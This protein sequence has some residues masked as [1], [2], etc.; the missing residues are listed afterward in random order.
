MDSVVA[1]MVAVALAL[2]LF[3]IFGFVLVIY[4]RWLKEDCIARFYI[5][6]QIFVSLIVLSLGGY[7]ASHVHGFQTSFEFFDSASRFPYYKIMYYGAVGQAAFGVLGAIMSL[8]RLAL[9]G[10]CD[11]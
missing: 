7:V 5:C 11:H 6:I 10:L 1:S 4:P 2:A 9:R 3:S 8:L